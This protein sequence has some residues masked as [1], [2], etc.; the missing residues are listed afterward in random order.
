MG[1]AIAMI[2]SLCVLALPVGVIGANFAGVWDDYKHERMDEDALR[3]NQ[4][5][6]V[7]DALATID[8]T[9]VSRQLY[10]TVYH[11]SGMP[12]LENNVFIGEAECE[13]GLPDEGTREVHKQI[14]LP[15]VEN[16]KKSDRTVSGTIFPNYV[17][18]PE[19]A[20]AEADTLL[21]GTLALTVVEAVDL[22]PIDWTNPGCADPYVEVTMN[23]TSP[24]PDGKLKE[25]VQITETLVQTLAPK[26]NQELKWEF[27]WTADGVEAMKDIQKN[28]WHG[29]SEIAA[30]GTGQ[31]E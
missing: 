31:E 2:W 30:E 8:P 6:M 27:H 18:T 13:L 20:E 4:K 9:S 25:Q 5:R 29:L 17:W 3:Q 19:A 15:L 21:H 24:G 7:R 28:K 10:V 26:W 12:N 23:P 16:R 14:R 22:A 11:N 1:A